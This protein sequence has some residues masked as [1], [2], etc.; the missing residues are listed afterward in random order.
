MHKA[1]VG[2]HEAQVELQKAHVRLHGDHVEV[3]RVHVEPHRA[4]YTGMLSHI[5]LCTQ[6]VEV[7]RPAGTHKSSRK[8]SRGKSFYRV[9]VHRWI[10]T[11]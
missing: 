6:D 2:V 7:Q 9:S 11:T 10:S 5:V 8:P 3:H 4:E 1:R